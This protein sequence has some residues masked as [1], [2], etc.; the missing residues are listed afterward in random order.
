MGLLTILKKMKQKERE[1]R[2]LMLYP[3]SARAVARVAGLAGWAEPG[4]GARPPWVPIAGGASRTRRYHCS[5]RGRGRPGRT[6]LRG[7]GWR[8]ESNP[9]VSRPS[10]D[11]GLQYHREARRSDGDSD[12]T[13]PRAGPSVGP[14]PP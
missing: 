3:P 13:L 9:V 5:A 12:V 11:L 8:A 7:R 2:L 4:V 14:A 1:L 10:L 6:T